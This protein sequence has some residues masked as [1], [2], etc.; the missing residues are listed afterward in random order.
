MSSIAKCYC[1]KEDLLQVEHIELLPGTKCQL[2][3]HHT[4]F[5]LAFK[6][7]HM[8]ANRTLLKVDF[9]F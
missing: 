2:W 8:R 9:P 6:V 5:S 4:A 7:Q 1:Q 3:F